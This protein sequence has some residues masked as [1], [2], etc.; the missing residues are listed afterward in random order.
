MDDRTRWVLFLAFVLFM[1]FI[2]P[3]ILQVLYPPPPQ[4]AVAEK[5]EAEQAGEKD[6]EKVEGET[7]KNAT[8]S[9]EPAEQPES[10]ETARADEPQIPVAPPVT[11]G[12]ADENSPYWIQARFN[13]LGGV[14][15]ELI[16]NRYRNENQT[17]PLAL[18]SRTEPEGPW[19]VLTGVPFG[20]FAFD[21][22]DLHA[23]LVRKPWNVSPVEPFADENGSELGLQVTFHR[24]VPGTPL[25]VEKRYRIWKEKYR[26]DLDITLRNTGNAAIETSY[27]LYGPRGTVLEGW[28]YSWRKRDA[29]VAVVREGSERRGTHYA[30]SLAKAARRVA[31]EV[32]A[33]DSNG[34]GN[35]TRK[36]WTVGRVDPWPSEFDLD[37][38]GVLQQDEL[39]LYIHITAGRD[40]RWDHLD[41][42][43][44]AGTE[45]QY[46]SAL[47]IPPAETNAHIAEVWPIVNAVYIDYA[48]NSDVGVLIK[49]K[50][51]TIEPGQEFIASYTLYPGPRD[52]GI[53]VNSI[54]RPELASYV[55]DF[56]MMGGI[57]RLMLAILRFFHR[58]IPNWGVSII[59]LTVVVRLAMHP[60]TRRQVISMQR[61][62][63]KMEK[64]KPELDK[65]KEKYKD[66][67]EALGR[68][69]LELYRKHGINPLAPL[70]G[71]LPLLVQMPIFIGLWR[72]LSAAVELR[73]APFILWIDNLAAP[74]MF[75]PFGVNLPILG[76]YLNLLPLVAIG[77]MYL[78]QKWFTPP[79]PD[80]EVQAQQRIT[81][82]MMTIFMLF[83]FYKLPS[84]LC[85]YFLASTAWGLAER[86][87][88]PKIEHIEEDQPEPE[89]KT[90]R[91]RRKGRLTVTV[92]DEEEDDSLS[93][94]IKKS[95]IAKKLAELIEEA[96]KKR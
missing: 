70:Q 47:L 28:W 86:K 9:T 79:S 6:S 58:I 32:S 84:G 81:M 44:F 26:L 62:Q 69:T 5:A 33:L 49:S 3:M 34:D 94:R 1:T 82:I 65:L 50:P 77:L 45:T 13:S 35:L 60:L 95:Y 14:I 21:L 8:P 75:L 10:R 42:L 68:A 93:A 11:V 2:T 25:E 41:K 67:R 74:D 56:G 16:L 17:G 30:K 89:R 73:Q 51:L 46:F 27:W 40:E 43:L 55:S 78:Q 83:I 59:L 87:L 36:E 4:P 48:D 72:A 37:A 7:A 53:F 71:C 38:D 29:A 24:P 22:P 57:A 23:Q 64:I 12:S 52:E 18:L 76:P 96:N 63:K 15:D 90:A 88:I 54:D 19:R 31:E 85:L 91:R 80:P 20:S 61:M 92:P 39:L 66:D